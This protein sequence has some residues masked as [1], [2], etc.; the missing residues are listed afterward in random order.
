MLYVIKLGR[1]RGWEGGRGKVGRAIGE[2]SKAM[3]FLWGRGGVE[4][5]RGVRARVGLNEVGLG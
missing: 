4:R 3:V 2:G 1:G 5:G